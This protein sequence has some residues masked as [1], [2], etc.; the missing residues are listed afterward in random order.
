VVSNKKIRVANFHHETV[1]SAAELMGA[2][3]ISDPSKLHRSYIYRRVSAG[4]IQTY[5]ETYPYI[6]R[7]SLLEP[8]Y[9]EIYELDM[10]N[11]NEETFLPLIK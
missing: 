9:P 3:G 1:K 4:Q 6:L 11:C 7:G 5:A 10:A 2:A 8:P